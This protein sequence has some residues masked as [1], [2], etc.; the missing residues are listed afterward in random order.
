LWAALILYSI[1]SATRIVEDEQD[2]TA[3][4]PA[5]FSKVPIAYRELLEEYKDVFPAD[6]SAGLPPKR[7]GVDLVIPFQD[8]AVPVASY[9]MRYSQAEIEE[10]PQS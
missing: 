1:H 5:D 8:K 2:M 7:P 4:A 3:I 6:L 9:R 10:L